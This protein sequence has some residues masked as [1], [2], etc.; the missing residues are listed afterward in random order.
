MEQL[1]ENFEELIAAGALEKDT[2]ILT[3]TEM[4]VSLQFIFS[5]IL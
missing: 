4:I 1:F 2:R 3:T 5:E